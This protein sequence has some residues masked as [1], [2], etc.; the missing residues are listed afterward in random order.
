MLGLVGFVNR[1]PAFLLAPVA[2]VFIDRFDKFRILLWTQILSMLQA[3]LLAVLVLTHV[4]QVWHILVLGGLL[5]VVNSLDLPVRQSFVVDMIGKKEDLSNALALNSILVNVARLIGPTI[6]GILVALVGAGWC[7]MINAASYIAIIAGLFMMD[8]PSRSGGRVNGAVLT[9]LREGFRYVKDFKPIRNLLLLLALI[10]LMGM[11]YQV[12]MPVFAKDIFRGGSHVLGFL[13][14]AVGI[15]ALIGGFYLATLTTVVGYGRKIIFAT[16]VFGAS[17][18]IFSQLNNLPIALVVL[19]FTGLGMMM[20]M[21]S[22][23]TV[24]QT[25]VDDDKLGRTMS[26]HTVAFSGM[27]PFGNLLSGVLADAFGVR[28]AVFFGGS[29]CVA[30]AMYAAFR[31]ADMREL[32]KP[33]YIRKEIIH[34]DDL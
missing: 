6:A 3:A 5:G 31:L 27:V 8:V 17:L 26:F 19:L 33:V 7:F 1:L 12:L 11:P 25:L 20:Q 32:A 22:I 9:E 34:P 24:I 10:S 15:G 13:M 23:N 2:G 21:T 29:C 16:T 30:G 4:I 28:A 14:S 18:A